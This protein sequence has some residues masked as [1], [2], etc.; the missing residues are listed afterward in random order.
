MQP[1]AEAAGAYIFVAMNAK[2]AQEWRLNCNKEP[3]Q[4]SLHTKD[5]LLEECSERKISLRIK[6]KTD[7]LM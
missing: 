4:L 3:K 1:L 7:K 5:L 2:T 6:R